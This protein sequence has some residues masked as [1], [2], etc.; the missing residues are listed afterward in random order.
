M[1][2]MIENN[3]KQK[4]IAQW[5]QDYAHKLYSWALHKVSDKAIAEDL[6]QDTFLA[7]TESYEKFRGASSP[8]TWLFRILN[9]K[10]MD[11]YRKSFK[12]P[13][14]TGFHSHDEHYFSLDSYFDQF[15]NWIKKKRPQE[16]Q[17]DDQSLLDN[18]SFRETLEMCLK[19]LPSPWLAVVHLK[20]LEE[21]HSKDI[22]HEL[23]ITP[24]NFW[25]IL[26][27]AKITLRECLD[28]HW[29]KR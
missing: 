20:Y 11:H 3:G 5:A 2:K 14:L 25:Q 15:G 16:W 27:R 18:E 10:I 12:N 21:K 19:N 28:N 23:E 29:F 13:E 4:I 24:S 26:H 8:H 1:D 9:N 22:Y 7:A 17:N 6:V